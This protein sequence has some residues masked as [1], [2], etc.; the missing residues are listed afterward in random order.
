MEEL[1]QMMLNI[2]KE[3]N[4]TPESYPKVS[5]MSTDQSKRE[6]VPKRAFIRRNVRNGVKG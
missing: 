3:Q 6:R 1:K 5:F 2:Q 4:K